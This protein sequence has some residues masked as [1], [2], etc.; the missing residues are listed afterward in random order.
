[1]TMYTAHVLPVICSWDWTQLNNEI[2]MFVFST[3]MASINTKEMERKRKNTTPQVFHTQEKSSRQI[4]KQCCLCRAG[5]FGIFFVMITFRYSRRQNRK[6]GR[7]TSCGS[8][9]GSWNCCGRR[10]TTKIAWCRST[11]Y[12]LDSPR[13]P[14]ANLIF[15]PSDLSDFLLQNCVFPI[16]TSA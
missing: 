2:I 4:Q 1:M 8:N 13:T 10:Q 15:L 6:S 14:S 3:A 12:Y 7:F 16:C 5:I 11:F 9:T